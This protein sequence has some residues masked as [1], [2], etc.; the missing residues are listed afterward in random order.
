MTPKVSAIIPVYN[1]EAVLRCAV[2]SLLAQ[3]DFELEIVVVDDGSTDGSVALAERMQSAGA[4][5]VLV[6][7]EANQGVASARNSGLAA[8]SHPLILFLDSDDYLLPGAL[9]SLLSTLLEDPRRGMACGW[10][11]EVQ[12][13]KDGQQVPIGAHLGDPGPIR[14]EP[15][16]SG[17]LIRLGLIEQVGGF[18]PELRTHEDLDWRS[19]VPDPTHTIGEFAGV[20]F[21]RGLGSDNLTVDLE[22]M[23]RSRLLWVRKRLQRARS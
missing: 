10:R 15:F 2:A 3:Q 5:I 21:H 11:R 12:L 14:K 13:P 9:T 23:R 8:G 16:V 19:R 6:E 17:S 1:R 7:H 4:P 20:T 22:A 18:D